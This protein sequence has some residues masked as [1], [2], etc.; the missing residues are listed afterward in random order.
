MRWLLCKSSL[1]FLI[2]AALGIAGVL[3][4]ILQQRWELERIQSELKELRSSLDIIDQKLFSLS[5]KT[6]VVGHPQNQSVDSEGLLERSLGK[7]GSNN[8]IESYRAAQTVKRFGSKA[9]PGLLDLV[10]NGNGHARKAALALLG[11]FKD[12][13]TVSYLREFALSASDNVVRAGALGIL[14]KMRDRGAKEIFLQKLKDS[15]KEV[16]QAAVIG[17]RRLQICEAIP[18]LIQLQSKERGFLANEVEKTLITL[19]KKDR[20]NTL[21][22]IETLPPSL[23]FLAVQILSKDNS[24]EVVNLLKDLLHD[25][26]PR[27]ALGSARILSERGYEEGISFAQE[28]LEND[29]VGELHDIAQEILNSLDSKK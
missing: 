26:D 28:F 24:G 25:D 10:A 21:E 12:P 18:E 27:V 20:K 17:V 5:L 2:V 29:P 11:Y 9:I 8:L 4:I 22:E 14:A 13:T 16:R 6:D 7:L 1:F 23:R 3:T 19:A 15:E